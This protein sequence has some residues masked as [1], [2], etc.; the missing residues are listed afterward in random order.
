MKRPIRGI[1]LAPEQETRL[2]KTKER[3]KALAAGCHARL[4]H[5]TRT[6]IAWAI[7]RFPAE[8]LE[9]AK[10]TLHKKLAKGS[11]PSHKRWEE[12]LQKNDPGEIRKT[13][14]SQTKNRQ[15]LNSCHP[16]GHALQIYEDHHPRR[17]TQRG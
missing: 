3:L 7:R 16:F 12:I 10:A 14:L 5:I 11:D 4:T 9:A 2:R 17:H 6:K 13:L 15:E 8:C 1:P